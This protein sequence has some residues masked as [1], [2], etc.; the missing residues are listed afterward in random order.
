MTGRNLVM[1]LFCHEKMCTSST[2]FVR[3]DSISA[4]LMKKPHL[5]ILATLI[6][7]A[8]IFFVV[9]ITNSQKKL[10]SPVL[11][12]SKNRLAEN[13][14]FPQEY[15]EVPEDQ[16]VLKK[17]TSEA[18]FFVE[19]QTGRVL[20][21]KN[22]HKK[23]S[24]ASLIKIMAVIVALEHK[25]FDDIYQ[26]SE[27]A[28]EMEPDKM[29]LIK[30]EK[31]SLK[32]LLQGIFLVSA[33][34]ASEVIAEGTT[35]RREEF[36]NLMNSKAQQLGMFNTHFVNPTGLEEDNNPQYSTA[37]DVILM[38][39]YAIKRWPELLEITSNPHIFIEATKDHQDYDLYNGI[40]LIT[41]Y[42][43]VV[44]FK[45]GYTPEAGLTLVILARKGNY[46]VLGV[47]LGAVERRD[48]ARLLLDY[49]FKK[50]GV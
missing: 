49:S 18:V 42:P 24:I 50:L 25:T 7:L 35:G 1:N 11:G 12:I 13:I 47:L 16:E 40:N 45:T 8:S 17:I 5:L 28:A 44:G 26:V 2:N 27:K 14:W 23:L 29:L 33:N 39:S 20:V 32:K 10:V 6:L 34:D 15:K 3:M 22:A 19:T 37:Y 48:D 30:G 36:I 46:E 38:S 9:F 31:I 43:G 41:T 21:E 4:L